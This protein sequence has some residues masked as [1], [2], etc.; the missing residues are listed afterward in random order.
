MLWAY[1][2]VSDGMVEPLRLPHHAITYLEFSLFDVK[3]L[4]NSVKITTISTLNKDEFFGMSSDDTELFLSDNYD[5]S[6]FKRTIKRL[7]STISTSQFI[8]DM[9]IR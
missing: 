5:V 6:A 8:P 4:I 7:F 1:L 2:I 9:S 3:M